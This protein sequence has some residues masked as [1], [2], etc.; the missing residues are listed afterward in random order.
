MVAP[1]SIFFVKILLRLSDGLLSTNN[2]IQ[3]QLS[4]GPA[5]WN[6]DWSSYMALI[7]YNRPN[8]WAF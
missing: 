1:N 3:E 5:I 6:C 2:P 4:N 8:K 7:L